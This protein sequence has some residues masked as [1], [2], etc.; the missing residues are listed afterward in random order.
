MRK[1]DDLCAPETRPALRFDLP[2]LD[3]PER[4]N[5]A[6]ILLEDALANGWGARAAYHHRGRTITYADLHGTVHRYAAAMRRLGARPGD[7]VLVRIADTPELVYTVLAAHAIGAVAIP[8]YV[9]L[10]AEDLAYRLRDA[11]ARFAFVGAELLDEM[12]GAAALSPGLAVA[13]LPA[14]P[15]GRFHSL[16]DLLPAGPAAPA[17]HDSHAEDLTLI[18]YTSGSTGR[19]KGACHCHR[20]MIALADSY[21]R[22]CIAPTPDDVIGG[23]PAAA[24]ALGYGMFVVFPLRFGSAAVLEPDKSVE[25]ALEAIE[26]YG[27]TIF[28]GVSSYFVALAAALEGSGRD[29]SSLRRALTGGEP[30]SPET[31]RAWFDATGGN[32]LEQF[33]GTSELFHVFVTSSRAEAAAR[34]ATLGRAVPGYEVAAVDPDT[35]A[36]VP[37]GSQGLLA[38]RGPTGTVYWKNPEKQAEAVRE[39]WNVFPDLVTRDADGFFHYIARHDEMIVSSGYNISPIEVETALLR[40]RA[41]AECAAVAAPDPTGRRTAIVKAYVVLRPGHAG[42]AAMAATLQDHAKAV[43]PPYMYP[44]AVA[45]L[46]ALPKTMNGKVLRS[47][48]RARAHSGA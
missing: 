34:G 46:D 11:G 48:L 35:M 41:V 15:S 29:I 13:A 38:V 40:H 44:R 20:D 24:F 23:P 33:L 47:E 42:D 36:P 45:F 43:A 1:Y 21:W 12:E 4:M 10:R 8:T 7:R 39:G 3:Y 5:A 32:V 37:D 17:Y 18:V 26:R 28:A 22:H 6:R 19:P 16:S 27:I 9:Q 14:D 2:G 31:E 30:L 25:T